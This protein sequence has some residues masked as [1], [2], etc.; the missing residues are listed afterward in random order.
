MAT[1]AHTTTSTSATNAPSETNDIVP[2]MTTTNTNNHDDNI[3]SESTC[4]MTEDAILQYDSSFVN[5]TFT[6]CV[7]I[8]VDT[9][10]DKLDNLTNLKNIQNNVVENIIFK[11]KSAISSTRSK[12]AKKAKMADEAM[13]MLHELMGMIRHD[14]YN[15]V[16]QQGNNN[17]PN[18]ENNHD[19]ALSNARKDLAK[20]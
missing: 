11:K 5:D 16:S 15:N 3:N 18:D 6:G 13:D 2:I 14:Y 4:T 9:L 7:G 12:K 20:A 8:G 17:N 1:P 19:E 10:D